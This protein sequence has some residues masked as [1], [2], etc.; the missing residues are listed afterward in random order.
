LLGYTEKD[1]HS[2]LASMDQRSAQPGPATTYQVGNGKPERFL[3]RSSLP[4]WGVEGRAIGWLIVLRDITQQR[5]IDE[6]RELITETLIHDLRSPLSA[7]LGALDVI[8]EGKSQPS[9]GGELIGQALSVARRAARRVLAMVES[10]LDIARMES[11]DMEIDLQ[12]TQLKPVVEGVVSELL[13]QANDYGVILRVEI[14]SELPQ[15]RVDRAKI[16]RVVS[17]ILDNAIKFTPSG[18]QVLVACRVISGEML[19]VEISDSGPGIPQE[20]REKIFEPFSQVPEQRGRRRGS[21]LGLTFCKLA[22]EAHGGRIWVEE[23][24]G[25]GSLFTFTLPISK[26]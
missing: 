14:P 19:A 26:E 8:E 15:V 6:D 16:T 22:V 4:V 17:N 12:D 11:G 23:G 2:L 18:G 3:E 5:Q 20:F 21:G 25:G 10:L 9:G 24:P 1:V 13:P 7:V